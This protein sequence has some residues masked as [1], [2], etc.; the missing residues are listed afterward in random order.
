[1]C[2]PINR[3]FASRICTFV[4][5]PPTVS[6]RKLLHLGVIR[7]PLH[8]G[9]FRL[10]WFS[11][12]RDFLVPF[13]LRVT[14]SF[15]DAAGTRFISSVIFFFPIS[16]HEWLTARELLSWHPH[17]QLICRGRRFF[18]LAS[19]VLSACR[20]SAV[21]FRLRGFTTLHRT[22]PLSTFFFFLRLPYLVA[23]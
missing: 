16:F 19:L 21:F 3:S 1:L 23:L 14:K 9:P 11:M 15:R 17:F 13:R 2:T 12:R 5:A 8:A 7:F 20:C 10:L 18:F 22:H 4:K 6:H